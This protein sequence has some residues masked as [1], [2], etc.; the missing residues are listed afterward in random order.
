MANQRRSIWEIRFYALQETLKRE[1]DRL[2][3]AAAYSALNDDD[4]TDSIERDIIK[5]KINGFDKLLEQ[6]RLIETR[7]GSMIF[8]ERDTR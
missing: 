8:L 2:M 5:S 7:R 3:H 6:A 4:F 1:R